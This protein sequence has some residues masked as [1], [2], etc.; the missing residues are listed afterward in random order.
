MHAKFIDQSCFNCCHNEGH[1]F[2]FASSHH[3]IDRYLFYSARYKVWWHQA[4][5]FVR[6]SGSA[7]K[8]AIDALRGRRYNR[9]SIA[10]A[11][12]VA[13]FNR[14]LTLADLNLARAEF[15]RAEADRQSVGNARIL[16]FGAAAGS[17][18]WQ[19]DTQSRKTTDI[20]P[21]FTE[22]AVSSLNL[23]TVVASDQCG[24][25]FAVQLPRQ[26]QIFICDLLALAY[27]EVSGILNNNGERSGAASQ[28]REHGFDQGAGRAGTL[29]YYNE[30]IR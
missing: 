28:L 23:D 29:K 17:G 1:I 3:R 25:D 22:P 30:S 9:Q 15:N 8:H 27:G 10:P 16:G 12:L 24:N 14:I 4:Q 19:I 20:L 26:I 2:G 11:A 13:G 21:I 7:L 18:S 5:Y 6:G